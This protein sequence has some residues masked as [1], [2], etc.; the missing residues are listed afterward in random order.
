MK[1][2]RRIFFKT[3]LQAA[4]VYN[5]VWGLWVGL[6]PFALFD[7][8]GL[9]RPNYPEIWQCVGMIVGVYGVGYWIA[10]Y[11]PHRHWPIVFVGFLGKI[12]GPIGFAY[13]ISQDVYNLKFAVTIVTNDLIWWIPFY[14]ILESAFNEMLN[15]K[16]SPKKDVSQIRKADP[17][18]VLFSDRWL[19]LCVRHSGCTFCREELFNFYQFEQKFID[20]GLRTAVIHMGPTDSGLEMKTKYNLQKTLFISDQEQQMYRLFDFKR[21]T[22]PQLVGVKNWIRGFSAGILK[23]HGVGALEGD[24]KQLGGV[25][26]FNKGDYMILHQ[27]AYAGDVG[28]F[29]ELLKKVSDQSNRL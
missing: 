25:V 10:S 11:D 13:A 2:E 5:I 22:W 17:Y 19:V 26:Y 24:G 6:F 4:A 12:F 20:L 27:S 1:P 15:P 3:T 28:D 18:S 7:F 8:A 21:G 16:L 9:V 23:G 14:L 29:M